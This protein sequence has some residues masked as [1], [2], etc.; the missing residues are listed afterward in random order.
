MVTNQQRLYNLALNYCLNLTWLLCSGLNWLSSKCFPDTGTKQLTR[1]GHALLTDVTR[2]GVK[3]VLNSTSAKNLD[4]YQICTGKTNV[5]RLSLNEHNHIFQLHTLLFPLQHLV[6]FWNSNNNMSLDFII[7]CFF[8]KHDVYISSVFEENVYLWA[9]FIS[10][11]SIETN[12]L[13]IGKRGCR[14]TR[15]VP[16]ASGSTVSMNG[17]PQSLQRG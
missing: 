4:F 2:A 5:G 16:L 1:F 7:F 12:R 11:Q 8:F 13:G 15:G 3:R 6:V 14:F 10:M 17:H 9:S